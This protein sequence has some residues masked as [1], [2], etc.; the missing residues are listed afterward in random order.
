M[1]LI[2]RSQFVFLSDP[3]DW[4]PL[5]DLTSCADREKNIN[6]AH[7]LKIRKYTP[8]VADIEA[9][10]RAATFSPFEVCSFGNIRSDPRRT[11]ASLVGKKVAKRVFKQLARIAISS[12]YYIFKSRRSL[13][14]YAPPLFE[15]QVVT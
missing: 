3:D 11:L 5:A 7:A 14:W 12:S 8:L 13:E 1:K 10:G 2:F 15:K 4:S 6:E 9:T